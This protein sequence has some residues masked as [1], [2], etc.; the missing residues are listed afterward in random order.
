[1]E[2]KKGFGELAAML[3]QEKDRL[4]IQS[5]KEKP[6][7]VFVEESKILETLKQRL[8][9]EMQEN[10]WQELEVLKANGLSK[11]DFSRGT[12]Y[13]HF[14]RCRHCVWS[15]FMTISWKRL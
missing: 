11:D 15:V 7:R 2:C 6:E 14:E 9:N 3:L 4:P 10:A 12:L 1:M 8:E 5:F 13:T